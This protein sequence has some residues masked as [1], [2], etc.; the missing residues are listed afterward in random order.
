MKPNQKLKRQSQH[1]L[2]TFCSRQL[3]LS[4][5]FLGFIWGLIQK[6]CL[7]PEQKTKELQKP[8]LK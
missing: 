6:P 4:G 5:A 8:L 2:A 7:N 1:K 3:L